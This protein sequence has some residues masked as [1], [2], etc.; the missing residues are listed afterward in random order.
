[1]KRLSLVLLG[2]V[3]M[4]FV[5]VSPSF[6]QGQPSPLGIVIQPSEFQAFIQVS[7]LCL[8]R[9]A[10]HRDSVSRERSPVLRVH[11]RHPGQ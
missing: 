1:M 8:R 4:G 9:R 6:S 3:L 11:S 2:V 10:D 7:R 5:G